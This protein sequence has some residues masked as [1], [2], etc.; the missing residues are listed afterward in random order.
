M[1][2]DLVESLEKLLNVAEVRVSY[3][4]VRDATLE[5]ALSVL[6]VMKKDINKEMG[7]KVKCQVRRDDHAWDDIF[8]NGSNF[9]I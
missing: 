1:S 9:S 5:G 4:T 3:S 2:R 8:L 7:I 6:E